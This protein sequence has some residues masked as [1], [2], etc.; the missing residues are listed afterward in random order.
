MSFSTMAPA[1]SPPCDYIVDILRSGRILTAEQSRISQNHLNRDL[2]HSN[3][4]TKGGNDANSARRK[5][6][7]TVT[8]QT[9]G[10]ARTA[11]PLAPPHGGRP[12]DGRVFPA[13]ETQLRTLLDSD[14]DPRVILR[15]LR[16]PR[17][18]VCDFVFAEVND[19]AC[20]YNGLPRG[21]FVGR[22]LLELFPNARET[23]LFDMYC[24]ILATRE[25]LNL[26]DYGYPHEIHAKMRRFDIRAIPV[27]DDLYH[28]WRDVTDG[29]DG[30]SGN[31]PGEH[32]NS[33]NGKSHVPLV[34]ERRRAPQEPAGLAV[35]IR[36]L[37]HLA[38][39]LIEA[40]EQ[41]QQV[42]SRE[43]HDNI[44]QVIAAA[45]NRISM[46]KDEKIPAWLRQELTDL[47]DQLK[48]ALADVRTLAR[49]MR[50]ALLDHFGLIAA[51]EKHAEAFRE[52][53]RLTLDLDLQ[54]VAIE[55]LAGDDLTHLFR[56]TQEALQNIEEH[57]GAE[58]AWIRLHRH[59]G[60]VLLEIGDDGCSFDAERITRAQADGHLGL[61][62]MRER[63]ELLGG[64]FHLEAIP[65]QGTTVR[66]KV[67]P[68]HTLPAEALNSNYENNLS[69]HH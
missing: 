28:T 1:P 46:A 64:Q 32:H 25:T 35:N 42:I 6:K 50:P 5:R 62:G 60:H 67:P 61:L 18:R 3:R 11:A 41:R 9:S 17:G 31:S 12:S 63:A 33:G 19:A 22:R 20:A 21:L 48:G 30:E 16:D 7:K 2:S 14:F 37:E 56:L 57:S 26:Q 15:A 23:G 40:G 10:D 34:L 52:R 49:D 8:K 66:V 58:R 47:R 43:L 44:A 24:R 51:L 68:P 27:G 53:T 38:Q 13:D 59:D 69:P 54:P 29:A 45:A 55:F 39:R 65:G 36:E 4:H